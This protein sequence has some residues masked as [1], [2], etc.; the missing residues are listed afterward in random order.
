[1]AMNDKERREVYSQGYT[2]G[3]TDKSVGRTSDYCWHSIYDSNEW[4]RMYGTGYRDGWK[5][6]EP[7][8]D[9]VLSVGQTT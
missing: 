7:S 8:D 1:M 5:G 6:I 3:R 2:S 4:V 9:I